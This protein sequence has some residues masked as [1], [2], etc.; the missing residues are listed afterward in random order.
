MPFIL[1]VRADCHL[2]DLARAALWAHNPDLSQQVAEFDIN[3]Q[4]AV[5]DHYCLRI[6][7]LRHEPSQQE[8]NWP[9]DT[10]QLRAWLIAV[11]Q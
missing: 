3:T 5:H 10:E 6:P 8:L 9:F 4:A 11:A 2:C 1:F 7:V